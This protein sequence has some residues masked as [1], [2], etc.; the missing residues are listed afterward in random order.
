MERRPS[1]LAQDE[2]GMSLDSIAGIG[3]R[4][5]ADIQVLVSATQSG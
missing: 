1:F 5:V 4:A 2:R 3:N